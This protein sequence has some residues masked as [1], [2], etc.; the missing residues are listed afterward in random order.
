MIS[1]EINDTI[2]IIPAFNEE[3]MITNVISSLNKYFINILVID[4]GSNDKTVERVAN[5]KAQII[6]LKK[7]YGVGK[8]LLTGL[9]VAKHRKYK[10]AI[11]VDG[12]GQHNANDVYKV[13]KELIKGYDLVIGQ[14]NFQNKNIPDTKRISNAIASN[15]MK[16]LLQN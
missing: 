5:L 2:I 8:A 10:F 9:Q 15:L 7:N 16:P 4:D 3:S 1:T 14:R 13:F 11:T 6:S 12:D